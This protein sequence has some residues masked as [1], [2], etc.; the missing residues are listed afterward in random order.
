[1][2]FRPNSIVTIVSQPHMAENWIGLKF[3]V[4]K[5]ELN[6]PY[7]LTRLLPL[8]E[9]PDGHGFTPFLWTTTSLEIW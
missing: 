5:A 3:K 2:N 9:R 6:D 1:M 4:L 8:S 7:Y